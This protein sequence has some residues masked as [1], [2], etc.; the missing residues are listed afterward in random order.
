MVVSNALDFLP[1]MT[2]EMLAP[3]RPGPALA[4]PAPPKLAF[5]FCGLRDEGIQGP[6]GA[7]A[8]P[9]PIHP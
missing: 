7:E 3:R 9:P 5:L 6:A 8:L 1:G 2:W 4:L